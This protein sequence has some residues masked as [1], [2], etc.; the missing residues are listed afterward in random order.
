M[1]TLWHLIISVKPLCAGYATCN[2]M[3]AADRVY[4][5]LMEV[6]PGRVVTYGDLARAAG[7]KNGSRAVGRFMSQNPYPGMVPCHRVVMSDGKLGGYG[8]GGE[9]IKAG[10]LQSEGVSIEGGRIRDMD[11][12]MYRF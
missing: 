4:A 7:I 2:N 3:K 8:F 10:L 12:L 5:K 9:Q 6:P 1:V 11:R